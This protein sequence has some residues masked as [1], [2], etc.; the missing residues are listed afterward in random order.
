MRHAHTGLSAGALFEIDDDA[1]D[2]RD[3][4]FVR[5]LWRRNAQTLAYRAVVPQHDAFDLGS[6]KVDAD[7]HARTRART[8]IVLFTPMSSKVE[9]SHLVAATRPNWK[10]CSR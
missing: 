4:F 3:A 8:S 9:A 5:S 6:T 7:P 2:R 1:R 10:R